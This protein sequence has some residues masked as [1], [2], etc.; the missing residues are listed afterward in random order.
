MKIKRIQLILIVCLLNCLYAN[1]SLDPAFRK[2]TELMLTVVDDNGNAIEG[3][4]YWVWYGNPFAPNGEGYEFIGETDKEGKL[5]TKA[6]GP[7][8]VTV[9]LEK[10]GFYSYGVRPAKDYRILPQPKKHEETITLRQVLNPVPLH[11]LFNG[12]GKI[13]VQNEWIGYDFEQGDWLEPYGKGKQADILFRYQSK[14]TGFRE[15]YAD[16]LDG[17]REDI[18]RRS[19]R[20]GEVFTEEA[21]RHEIGKW[22]GILEIAFPSKKEGIIKV[23]EAFVPQNQL[24]MP[25]KAPKEGYQPTHRLETVNYSNPEKTHYMKLPD[26]IGFFL[27]TRVVLD[28][29]GE[30]KSANYAKIY[31]EF[32]FDPR[33][34]VSFYYYYNPTPN[35]RNLEFDPEYNLFPEGTPGTFNIALP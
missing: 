35:E 33:G 15:A 6:V 23:E 10:E 21:F 3:V 14:F 8:G 34:K 1:A 29:Q 32:S 4:D 18:K 28:D 17:T 12:G 22:Y 20:I 7:F 26:D 27:Q 30:I 16:D 2:E 25:H 11:A 19:E 5:F 13:P 9:R 31:G 24:H